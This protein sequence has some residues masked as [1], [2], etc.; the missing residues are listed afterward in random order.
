M[1]LAKRDAK[2][3][4]DWETAQMWPYLVFYQWTNYSFPKEAIRETLH[5][6]QELVTSLYSVPGV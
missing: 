4:S 2:G 1:K 6:E 5:N 3:N